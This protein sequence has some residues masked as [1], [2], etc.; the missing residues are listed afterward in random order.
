[1]LYPLS[2][3]GRGRGL[4]KTW[5]K[6]YRSRSGAMVERSASGRFRVREA[7]RRGCG[8]FRARW[9]GLI[10]RFG[11]V[12]RRLVRVRVFGVGLGRGS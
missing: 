8:V 2:Y 4:E 10:P 1:M 3:E 11:S 6:T 9:V 5:E 12:R 7:C